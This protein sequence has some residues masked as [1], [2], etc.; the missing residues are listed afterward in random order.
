MAGLYTLSEA[1]KRSSLPGWMSSSVR[2]AE[3]GE[4]EQSVRR[5]LA[6]F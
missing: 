5:S 3:S 4:M 2:K 1:A 6:I